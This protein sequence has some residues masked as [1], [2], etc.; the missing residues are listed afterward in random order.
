MCEITVTYQY[1]KKKKWEWDQSEIPFKIKPTYL[2]SFLA[3]STLISS[4][5]AVSKINELPPSDRDTFQKSPFLQ[6]LYL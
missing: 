1:L 3:D 6:L 4:S 5:S 2:F